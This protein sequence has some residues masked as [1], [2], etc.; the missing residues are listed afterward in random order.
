MFRSLPRTVISRAY[1]G[2]EA[3]AIIRS[4]VRDFSNTSVKNIPRSAVCLQGLESSA[5][6]GINDVFRFLCFYE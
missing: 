5:N 2:G 1:E 4:V 3:A 6:V